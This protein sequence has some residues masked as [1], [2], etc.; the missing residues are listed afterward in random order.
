MSLGRSIEIS[1]ISSFT[2]PAHEPA[3]IPSESQAS[4]FPSFSDTSFERMLADGVTLE[5]YVD[6]CEREY[7]TYTLQKYRNSYKAAAALGT[8]QTSVMRRKKKYGI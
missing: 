7:L 4:Q 1:D 3:A 5:Q 8:S 2:D 6:T